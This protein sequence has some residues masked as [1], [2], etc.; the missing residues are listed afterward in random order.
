SSLDGLVQVLA[1]LDSGDEIVVHS[2]RELNEGGRVKV[3]E[4]LTGQRQ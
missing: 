3:V 1:G 4:Q 2:E